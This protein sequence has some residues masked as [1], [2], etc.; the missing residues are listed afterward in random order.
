MYIIKLYIHTHTHT[1]TRNK[2]YTK[3]LL[4]TC[5]TM[6]L[7]RGP[8]PLVL[9]FIHIM[10]Y[11]RISLWPTYV[12]CPGAVPSQPPCWH[13][14]MRI[15]KTKMTLPLWWTAQQQL[16]HPCVITI[17]FLL[18][19][20][21]RIIPDTMRKINSVSAEIRTKMKNLSTKCGQIPLVS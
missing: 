3:W 11:G 17:V 4:T 8:F 15:W 5:W 21:Y 9:L 1:H 14:S 19:P 20:K 18:K 7:G 2:L 12:S 16:K 10:A 13:V 6:S